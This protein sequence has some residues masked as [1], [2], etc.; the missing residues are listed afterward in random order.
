MQ[1]SGGVKQTM[2]VAACT[3]TEEEVT[4]PGSV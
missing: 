2:Q 3:V 1:S 4:V